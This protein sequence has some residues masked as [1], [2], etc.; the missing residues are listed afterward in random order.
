MDL[1]TDRSGGEEE[2][3]EGYGWWCYSC[4]RFEGQVLISSYLGRM[5]LGSK[6]LLGMGEVGIG[7]G[8]Q[9]KGAGAGWGREG[10][11]YWGR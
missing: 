10:A 1:V 4:K 2:E 5:C 3:K 7:W 6:Y 8:R 11:G 9:K